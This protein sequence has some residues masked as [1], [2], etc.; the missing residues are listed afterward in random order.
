MLDVDLQLYVVVALPSCFM[1]RTENCLQCDFVWS[2]VIWSTNELNLTC[3]ISLAIFNY[4]VNLIAV[5]PA[6]MFYTNLGLE[7]QTS[8]FLVFQR[9]RSHQER[10]CSWPVMPRAGG[11]GDTESLSATQAA[12]QA[13]V[14]FTWQQCATAKLI[15]DRSTR[16]SP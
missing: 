15:G 4:K 13:E 9:E 3:E 10:A 14:N 5:Y 8:N 1:L 12:S 16:E 7:S 6:G 2:K 11:Q